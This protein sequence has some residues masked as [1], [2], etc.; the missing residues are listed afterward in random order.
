M[1]GLRGTDTRFRD[2]SSRNPAWLACLKQE[3]RYA[4]EKAYRCLAK[5][6]PRLAL[7]MT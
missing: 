4:G 1:W 3:G 2:P 6:E 7:R 5:F